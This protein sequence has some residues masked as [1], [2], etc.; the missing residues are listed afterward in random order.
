MRRLLPSP[1]LSLF[2]FGMWL[3]LNQ[4]LAPG[5]L[6]LGA[7]LALGVP[8]LTAGTRP[9]RPRIRRPWLLLRLAAV[10]LVDVLAS[11]VRVS[12]I[13]LGGAERREHSGF[14]DIPLDLHDPHGLAVLAAIVNSTPGT[15]WAE[16][17]EDRRLL[18]LHV[19]D[20]RDEQAWIDTIKTRYEKPLMAIFQ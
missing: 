6:L 2:L 5:Q 8:A 4:S 17:S 3:M 18:T 13:I 15:V 11:C 20:L 7:A 9:L 19:L 10:V 12:A 14:M 1:L 16:L